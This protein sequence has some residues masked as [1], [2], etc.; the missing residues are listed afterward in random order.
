MKTA[1]DVTHNGNQDRLRMD[2]DYAA[3]AVHYAQW[4]TEKELK[5]RDP[6]ARLPDPEEIRAMTRNMKREHW[7]PSSLA[8]ASVIAEWCKSWPT[9]SMGDMGRFNIN[10]TTFHRIMQQMGWSRHRVWSGKANKPTY[11]YTPEAEAQNRPIAI[12][13]RWV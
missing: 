5:D 10:P 8:P 3:S 1:R 7:Q 13:G 11:Y 4:R 2:E 6:M 9:I 12:K